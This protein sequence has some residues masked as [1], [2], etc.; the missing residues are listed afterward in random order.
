MKILGRIVA[1]GKVAGLYLPLGNSELDGIYEIR[2]ILDEWIIVKIGV[3]T[4]IYGP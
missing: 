1:R 4:K 2:E 3:S